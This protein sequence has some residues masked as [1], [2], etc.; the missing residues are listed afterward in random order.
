MA[1]EPLKLTTVEET[2][3]Y[4]QQAKRFS[5]EW[6]WQ[7][8]RRRKLYNMQ[9]YDQQPRQGEERYNDP[10]YTNIVDLGVA[11]IMAND[12]IFRAHGWAP[13]SAEQ[14]ESDQIEKFL[15]GLLQINNER[16]EYLV[17][18]E[19]I[20]NFVR[21][22]MAVIYTVWDDEL[23]KKNST[24]VP[25]PSEDP[26]SLDLQIIPAF[27]EPPLRVQ[28]ID[29]RKIFLIPGGPNRWLH[30]FRVET[31]TVLDVEMEYGITVKRYADRLRREKEEIKG[32]LIDY[33]RMV[34]QED[35]ETG[36]TRRVVE[37]SIVFESEAIQELA[38]AEGYDD[39]PFT[40]G[41]F[42]PVETDDSKKWSHSIIDPLESTVQMI[43]KAVNRRQFQ[44][45]RFSALPLIAFAQPGRQITLDPA[46][47]SI[48]TLAPDEDLKFPAWQGSPP[49]VEQQLDFFRARAQQSGFSDVMFGSAGAMS[50]YG[51]SQ[52]GD[53]NR[54]R[55]EQPVQHLQLF[56]SRVAKKILHLCEH[57]ADGAVMRVYGRMRGRDFM[58]QIF[59]AGLSEYNVQCMIKPEFPNDQV[60]KHAMAT[61]VRTILSEHTIMERYLDIEQPD[62]ERER[63]IIEQMENHPMMVERAVIKQLREAANAGDVDAALVLEQMLSQ[64]ANQGGRPPTPPGGPANP[65]QLMGGM[66]PTG[67]PT[68]Q[69]MGMTPPGQGEMS[70]MQGAAGMSPNM[71]GGF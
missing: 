58:E 67:Q 14:K 6:H 52:L 19:T 44:I 12:I 45:T 53:Q 46:L 27:R 1:L 23:A 2:E 34:D 30:V 71:Q 40:I 37:H 60:R 61:Q 16:N 63:K 15:A 56:W 48:Q 65:E 38:V 5:T 29:P 39:L 68:P 8:A 70:M 35:P 50:G 9:H 55:L 49:D 51:L 26:E 18:Y 4:Y 57:F 42:K 17:Q 43:E 22:G 62:D 32:E 7:V 31:K 25:V 28:V 24:M 66:G 59:T 47:G 36:D 54:I 21:D 3:L 64:S 10:T 69:E 13:S 20:L 11:I 41:F 33:W